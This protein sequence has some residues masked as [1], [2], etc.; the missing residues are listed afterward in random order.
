MKFVWEFNG[1]D[2]AHAI[3]KFLVKDGYCNTH[4]YLGN[5]IHII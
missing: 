1:G 2:G 5:N 3:K 4:V